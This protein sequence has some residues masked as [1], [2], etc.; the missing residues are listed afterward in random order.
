VPVLVYM[1][2]VLKHVQYWRDC[3]EEARAIAATMHFDSTRQQMLAIAE[4]YERLAKQA[5]ACTKVSP[6]VSRGAPH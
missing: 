3:A 6:I 1:N 4:R 2:S 5:E